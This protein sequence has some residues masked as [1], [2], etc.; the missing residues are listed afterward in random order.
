MPAPYRLL[1]RTQGEANPLA[2]RDMDTKRNEIRIL[3]SRSAAFTGAFIFGLAVVALLNERYG[4]N[5]LQLNNLPPSWYWGALVLSSISFLLLIKQTISP[6][7]IFLMNEKGI[8]IGKGGG[9]DKAQFIPWDKVVEIKKSKVRCPGRYQNNPTTKKREPVMI[10][11]VEII[12]SEKYKQCGRYPDAFIQGNSVLVTETRSDD[13]QFIKNL[14][15]F[16]NVG[17]IE[18][19]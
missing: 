11:G 17:T 8:E 19:G 14:L 13:E 18:N 12:L 1:R 9:G 15:H 7:T 2:E 6:K 16:K 10:S 5:F 4:N 3:E